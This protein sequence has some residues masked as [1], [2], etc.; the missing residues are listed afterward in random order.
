MGNGICKEKLTDYIEKIYVRKVMKIFEEGDDR[1]DENKM[2]T[3]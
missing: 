1:M 3:K 2:Q